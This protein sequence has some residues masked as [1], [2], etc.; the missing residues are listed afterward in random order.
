MENI[1]TVIEILLADFKQLIPET[2]FA[3]IKQDLE[4]DYKFALDKLFA[5]KILSRTE[6]KQPRTQPRGP[7]PTRGPTQK[8]N[9]RGKPNT[10]RINQRGRGPNDRGTRTGPRNPPRPRND[11]RTN[12]PSQKKEDLMKQL[13]DIQKAVNKMK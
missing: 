7:K 8:Q 9:T 2:D 6:S 5:T 13:A 11:R 12:K 10:P 1:S 3:E 4:H